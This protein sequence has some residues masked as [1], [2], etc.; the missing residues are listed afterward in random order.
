LQ[1]TYSTGWPAISAKPHQNHHYALISQQH[2]HSE[3]SKEV[4]V[5]LA[6]QATQQ[7]ATLSQRH[8]AAIYKISQTTLSGRRA[9]RP[10]QAD[11]WPKSRNL[12]KPEEDVIVERI[13]K[14]VTRGCPTRLAAVA[15]IA[16]SLR[17][18]RS[19]G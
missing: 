7:N 13:T 18:E 12:D 2:Y 11:R 8:A 14:L 15:D 19:I 17:E 1:V 3:A 5:Q 4:Q 6:I 16:N 9:G 10:L